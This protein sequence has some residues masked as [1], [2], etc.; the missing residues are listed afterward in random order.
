MNVLASSA[1]ASFQA[2]AVCGKTQGRGF[3]DG[4]ERPLKGA[5]K[6]TVAI[7][8]RACN[9]TLADLTAAVRRPN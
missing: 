3:L 1:S 7:E 5:D 9:K 6:I 2:S 8:L 4:L